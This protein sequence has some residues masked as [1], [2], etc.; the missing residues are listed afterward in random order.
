MDIQTILII[1]GV[2]L[3]IAYLMNR[4]KSTI[5]NALRRGT[6]RPSFDN[7]NIQGRGSFGRNQDN[8]HNT[9]NSETTRPGSHN[10]G[11]NVIGKGGFG[12]DKS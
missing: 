5:N 10:D 6:E 11:P 7:P 2:V 1:V 9:S 8:Q 12:R 3:L 4:N